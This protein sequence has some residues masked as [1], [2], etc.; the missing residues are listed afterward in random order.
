[1]QRECDFNSPRNNEHPVDWRSIIH[2]I[3]TKFLTISK[4][5]QVRIYFKLE[6]E[7]DYL[8]IKPKHFE[9][10]ISEL[11]HNALKFSKPG[12]IVT[13]EVTFTKDVFLIRVKDTGIGIPRSIISKIF[14]KFFRNT[15]PA[16]ESQGAGLG[17]AIVKGIAKCNNGKITIKSKPTKGTVVEVDFSR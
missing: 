15:Q 10:I 9:Y 17:L 1:M 8:P 6:I 14:R 12:S 11:L 5:N 16:K 7:Q 3:K 4:K 2:R 13:V